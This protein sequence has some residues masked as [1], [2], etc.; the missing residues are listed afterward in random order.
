MRILR[1]F[2][3]TSEVVRQINDFIV[4]RDGVVEID[5][6]TG[7]ATVTPGKLPLYMSPALIAFLGHE[8]EPKPK[9][10]YFERVTTY[11]GQRVVDTHRSFDTLFIYCDALAPRIVGDSNSSLL[12]TLPNGSKRA[13]FGDTVNTRF[14]K[15]RYYPVAKRRFHTIR[16]DVRTDVGE[17]A[18]FEGGKV[19]VELH[20]RKVK[21]A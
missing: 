18:K 12:I 5:S 15:I 13:L 1:G 11:K 6:H 2:Y 7:K 4:D 8:F 17:P 20:F 16:I 3:T 10:G 9:N 14:I 19:F 21:S